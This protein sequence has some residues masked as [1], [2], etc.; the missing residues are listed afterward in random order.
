MTFSIAGRCARTGMFGVAITTSSIC[1]AARCP[2]ARAGAGAVATQNITDPAYGPRILDLL[3][4]GHDADDALAR[5][6][7][8]QPYTEYRQITVVDKAGATAVHSGA[9]VLGTHG[10]ATNEDCVAAGNLLKT[11]DVPA[12]M[13]DAFAANADRHLAERL[14]RALEAGLAAGGEAG[15]VHSAGLLVVDKLPFPLVD[16]RCD[17]DEVNPVAV[18]RKLWTDYAPQMQ[19][20]VDR[21][22]NPSAAPSYGVPGDL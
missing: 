16:L 9:K 7:E 5:A 1:V 17:W 21:A 8:G 3:A 12:A 18:L 20:Y 6:L 4:Q 22:V 19:A 15:P 14:L 10:V 2:H 11:P 13:A